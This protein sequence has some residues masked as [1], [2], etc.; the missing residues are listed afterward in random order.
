MN[1]ALTAALRQPCPVKISLT[2]PA[3]VVL[4][5][6]IL[7]L[8]PTMT[9]GDVSY[10]PVWELLRELHQ[11]KSNISNNACIVVLIKITIKRPFWPGQY[12]CTPTACNFL[13]LPARPNVWGTFHKFLGSP[14]RLMCARS[15]SERK[16]QS[17]SYQHWPQGAGQAHAPPFRHSRCS[18][19]LECSCKKKISMLVKLSHIHRPVQ[20][21][22]H[23]SL[24]VLPVIIA[25]HFGNLVLFWHPVSWSQLFTFQTQPP[26]CESQGLLITCG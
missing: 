2:L 24:L 20:K 12:I 15:S 6:K 10:I 19:K 3:G 23:H 4:P 5:V 1:A 25:S 7:I 11:I 14:E 9:P 13:S 16:F 18:P 26:S 8:F 21:T 22:S 17:S